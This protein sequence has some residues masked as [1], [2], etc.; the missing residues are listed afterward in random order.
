MNA[1]VPENAA[2]YTHAELTAA[3]EIVHR[4]MA[5]TACLRW[6]LLD[7]ALGCAAWV[8]HENQTPL[9]AF[10]VRGGLVYF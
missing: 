3:A 4:G 6:P 8:K 2:R 7:A 5:P 10:K 9:G 1:A